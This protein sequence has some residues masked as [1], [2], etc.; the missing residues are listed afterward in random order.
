MWWHD[1]RLAR[2]A[3]VLRGDCGS[4]ATVGDAHTD[5]CVLARW[6]SVQRITHRRVH[7]RGERL[8]ATDVSRR[9][10]RGKDDYPGRGNFNERCM[11][12]DALHD[13]LERTARATPECR[14]Q[15]R[16]L[17]NARDYD[18]RRGIEHDD[19]V[20]TAA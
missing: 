15:C 16:P 3:R 8:V 11:R 13:W 10:A 4:Q 2:H 14:C 18:T 12:H 17:R 9:P 19:T 7:Q 1:E 6:V 5:A 20:S